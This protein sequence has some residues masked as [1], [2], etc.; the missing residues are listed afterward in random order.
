MYAVSAESR[1]MPVF[2]HVVKFACAAALGLAV[3]LSSASAQ[4]GKTDAGETKLAKGT[5]VCS[6]SG[7]GQK[8]RCYRR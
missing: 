5:Y 4:G 7:F 8:S 1:R 2:I 3:S 6:P